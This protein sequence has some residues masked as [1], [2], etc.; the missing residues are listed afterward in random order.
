MILFAG[1]AFFLALTLIVALFAIKLSEERSGRRAMPSW[2]D[3]L[4][5]EALHIKGLLSAAELDLKKLPP[6]FV[7]WMHGV[8][9]IAALE[10]ARA[11]RVGR[12]IDWRIS[13]RTS[14]ISNAVL[15]VQSFSKKW[16]SGKAG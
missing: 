6:L 2:R 3:A 5:S 1:I 10:F 12:R 13:C 4:D 15:R 9:Q 7:Y 8:I 11:L 16:G 14:A